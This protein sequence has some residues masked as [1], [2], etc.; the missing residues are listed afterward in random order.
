MPA[1]HELPDRLIHETIDNA[2]LIAQSQLPLRTDGKRLQ[3][4]LIT[5]DE[6]GIVRFATDGLRAEDVFGVLEHCL[7]YADD[8]EPNVMSDEGE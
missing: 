8:Y 3:V 7:E 6:R 1:L 2:L 5:V 4:I